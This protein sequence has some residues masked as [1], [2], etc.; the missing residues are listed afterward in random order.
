MMKVTCEST[1]TVS[2]HRVFQSDLNPHGTVF[3]GKI[4]AIV[5]GEASVAA[6]RVT[7]YTMVTATMDHVRFLHPFTMDDAM[8]MQA[9]VTGLGHRSV[10]VFVKV[11]G[12]NLLT[13]D[14]F[15]GFTCMMTYVIQDPQKQVEYSEL[16]PKTDEQKILVESYHDRRSHRIDQQ[17]FEQ[18]LLNQI[19]LK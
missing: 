16:V 5:D 15:L 6:M 10:E 11:I 3:G 4:L 18:N 13:G 14:R 2:T 7:H 1:L 17:K 9:Y 8:I 12:E 19:T